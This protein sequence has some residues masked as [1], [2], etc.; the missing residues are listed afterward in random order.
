MS[1]NNFKLLKTIFLDLLIFNSQI[2]L[3]NIQ[4]YHQF[5]LLKS[6]LSNVENEWRYVFHNEELNKKLASFC[7]ALK[8][9]NKTKKA[10]VLESL[11]KISLDIN[12]ILSTHITN[13]VLDSEDFENEK[14][15]ISELK[16]IQSN[17]VQQSDIK[18]ALEKLH[19]ITDEADSIEL[20]LKGIEKD[21]ENIL[22]IFR[23][24][25]E[26]NAQLNEDIDKKSNEDIHGLYNKIYKLEIQ[27]ADK[28]RNWALGI[29]GVISF[30][31][32]WKL[33][34]V[35]LGFNKWGISFS[36]PSKAFGWEYFINVLVLVGLSTPAWY[37]TRESSKH[38]KVAYKAQSLGTELAAFPL[39]AREFKDEDRLELRKIL[40]DRFFGQ[41][42]YNNS[43]VGSN[44]DNSLEQI[45][46]LTEA[47]K[48]LAESLKIKK[49]TEAS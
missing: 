18:K 13:D 26:K 41:E 31:L 24:F 39:Y 1:H 48:V 8:T 32:I 5:N 6:N 37:L 21:Y 36:I 27:I 12:D 29:F 2:H 44:S 10:E 49:I 43:K 40:A 22:A 42:L 4:K 46:L 35:S 14:I 28:Y 11:E 15:L 17:F 47:N 7:A 38:R 33:F 9:Y 34:N 30:I 25:K 20:K 23:D 45:K 3:E 16:E 19:L